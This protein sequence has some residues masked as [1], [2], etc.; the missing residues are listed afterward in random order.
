MLAIEPY[1]FRDDLAAPADRR[2]Y[3]RAFPDQAS[4]PEVKK[5]PRV[6]YRARTRGRPGASQPAATIC[7]HTVPT[8]IRQSTEN[9]YFACN[10]DV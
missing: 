9:P 10:R 5:D 6:E 7:A 1:K 4:T 3:T 8:Q 2:S